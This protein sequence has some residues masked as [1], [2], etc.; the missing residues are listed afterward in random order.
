MFIENT[1]HT[2]TRVRAHPMPS[3][4]RLYANGTDRLCSGSILLFNAA[5]PQNFQAKNGA[6]VGQRG[7]T[8][9]TL[10]AIMENGIAFYFSS[11]QRARAQLA[12]SDKIQSAVNNY[13]FEQITNTIYLSIEQIY[14]AYVMEYLILF[15]YILR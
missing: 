12:E 9:S 13:P 10:D 15:I 2:H 11:I 7:E 3:S 14:P 4:M 6:N 8:I 1:A 5:Y